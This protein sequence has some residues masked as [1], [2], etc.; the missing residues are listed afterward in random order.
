MNPS[1][2]F[3]FFATK[4]ILVNHNVVLVVTKLNLQQHV[5]QM[6]YYF[7]WRIQDFPWG[8]RQLPNWVCQPIIC[9]FLPKTI[10]KWKNL[11]SGGGAR[12]WHPTLDPPMTSQYWH[13]RKYRVKVY[14]QIQLICQYFVDRSILQFSWSV[15]IMSNHIDR[16]QKHFIF[17]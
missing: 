7:Q 9:K 2:M 1:K 14:F 8:G 4:Q 10:W 13:Q 11:D 5:L 15:L 6:V 17:Q 16:H 3:L 12:P